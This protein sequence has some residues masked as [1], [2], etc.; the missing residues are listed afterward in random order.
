MKDCSEVRGGRLAPCERN[1]V[2]HAMRTVQCMCHQYG[3]WTPKRSRRS[4]GKF[5]G[6]GT[7]Q[8]LNAT[9]ATRLTV[10]KAM[11]VLLVGI[12]EVRDPARSRATA[13]EHMNG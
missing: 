3:A 5:R 12:N 9:K 13:I 11:L 10:C 1:E 4:N 7:A 2:S 6:H 8:C